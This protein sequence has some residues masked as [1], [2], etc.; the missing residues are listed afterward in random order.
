MADVVMK[1]DTEEVKPS[2]WFCSW[3]KE[4]QL[5]E[6]SEMLNQRWQASSNFAYNA[7]GADVES[8]VRLAVG[9]RHA[10]S[11]G[12]IATLEES[13]REAY[14]AFTASSSDHHA[15]NQSAT[16]QARHRQRMCCRALRDATGTADAR[17][18]VRQWQHSGRSQ[19][20]SRVV[21]AGRC[22]LLGCG[23]K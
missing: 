21:R 13:F 17:P 4:F 7:N 10:P 12:W 6:G 23:D 19:G 8:L 16:S 2:S 20:R 11:P 22:N 9:S 18:L 1:E 14:P 15:P 5:G 3:T